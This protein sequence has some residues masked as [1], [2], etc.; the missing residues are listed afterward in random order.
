VWVLNGSGEQ[1]QAARIAGYLDWLGLTVSA[2]NQAPVP[3]RL[4]GTRIVVYNGAEA[5]LPETVKVL[6]EVFGVSAQ[7]AA[8]PTAGA[9]IIVSTG[10]QTPE[11]TPPPAP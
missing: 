4:Q 7:V 10:R 8:D 11:L 1:G 3:P 6:E 2:P 9:D 5:R